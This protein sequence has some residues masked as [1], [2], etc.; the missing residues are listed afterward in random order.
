MNLVDLIVVTGQ[1]TCLV[2]SD[3]RDKRYEISDKA[4]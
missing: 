2:T 4:R 3:K 1:L